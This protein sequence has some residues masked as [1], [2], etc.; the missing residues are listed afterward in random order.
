MARRK[1]QPRTGRSQG[2]MLVGIG[3]YSR[4]E[5]TRLKQVA[6]DP[7]NLH[8]TYEEW[9]RGAEE[10]ERQIARPGLTLRRVMIDVDSLVAW[11]AARQKSVDGAA[12][13]EYIQELV[14][15]GA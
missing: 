13:S 5:W 7:D 11:C 14:R 10:A 3:W 6:V 1:S 8:D 12:R 15:S 2:S 4:A 9:V